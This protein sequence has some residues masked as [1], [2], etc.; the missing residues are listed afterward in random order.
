MSTAI[1][2]SGIQVYK[3]KSTRVYQKINPAQAG[4]EVIKIVGRAPTIDATSTT[5]GVTI[6]REYTKNIPTPGR[7]YAAVAGA[8]AHIGR[9]G[10]PPPPPLNLVADFGGG[11]MVLALGVV[12]AVLSARQ[13]GEGQV[14]DAYEKDNAISIG[15]ARLRD[16]PFVYVLEVGSLS[17]TESQAKALREYLLAGG[18]MVI[19]DFWG[20]WAWQNFEEQMR[21]VFP[22]R[23]IVDVPFGGAKGGIRIEPKDYTVE[24]L[25]RLTRRYTHELVK[26]SFIGPGIDVPAPDYGTGEREMAWIADTFATLNPGDI[27]PLA[28][29]TGKP[30]TSGGIRGRNEATGLENQ[31]WKDSWDSIVHPDGTLASLP[32]ATCELQGYA[33]D[34]RIRCARPARRQI[35]SGAGDPG[36]DAVARF[37]AAA[38]TARTSASRLTAYSS[39]Q[40]TAASHAADACA[41]MSCA[42]PSRRAALCGS[43]RS[44]SGTS[45][46][47]SS[48]S[49]SATRSTVMRTLPGLWGSPWTTHV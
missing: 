45:T 36:F 46:C 22:N 48:Q 41:A 4:G 38:Q 7:A 47:D 28:C 20:S 43:T 16:F 30:V 17:L 29:V 31:C 11:A 14:V 42:P 19:D 23:A 39:S 25:E 12:S 3:N 13:T 10:H 33:Y 27:D 1:E 34:A 32:R 6:N 40:Q 9:A 44:R 18:F 5:Q 35:D 37:A 21:L 2:R 15:E 8:L 24:E 49:I 26:K